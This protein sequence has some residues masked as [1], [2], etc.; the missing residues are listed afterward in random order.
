MKH[1]EFVLGCLNLTRIDFI[2]IFLVNYLKSY[3]VPS[4]CFQMSRK[5]VI[6]TFETALESS[7]SVRFKGWTCMYRIVH[8]PAL[9]SEKA[10]ETQLASHTRSSQFEISSFSTF[11][12]SKKRTNTFW[13]ATFASNI[14]R[15]SKGNFFKLH[16]S[17]STT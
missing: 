15:K 14:Q 9:H 1:F 13:L 7:E 12:A 17:V 11:N 8:L 5:R 2:K 3:N 10:S 4:M 16:V 6:E